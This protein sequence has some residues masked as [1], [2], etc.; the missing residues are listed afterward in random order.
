M[1]AIFKF[2]ANV[3][4]SALIGGIAATIALVVSSIYLE[5]LKNSSGV[6][7]ASQEVGLHNSPF[8]IGGASFIIWLYM[9]Y[10]EQD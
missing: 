7:L 10:Q 4:E 5:Q 2:I 8:I 1:K 3:M 6:I 9:K